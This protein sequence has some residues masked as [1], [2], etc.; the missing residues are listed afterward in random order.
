MGAAGLG[1][2]VDS[3][4]DALRPAC[5][6]NRNIAG[7]ATCPALINIRRHR[8]SGRGYR[9]TYHEVG[10]CREVAASWRQRSKT[11]R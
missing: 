9:G 1:L 5:F 6:W 11:R 7:P 10:L 8:R 2:D 4:L 3:K